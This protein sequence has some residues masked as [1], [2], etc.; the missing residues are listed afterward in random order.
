MQNFPTG[1]DSDSD[2]LIEM[3]MSAVL[4]GHMPTRPTICTKL[5]H[6]VAMA[7]A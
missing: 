7:A 6:A 5:H 4:T 3:Y 2:P 1:L